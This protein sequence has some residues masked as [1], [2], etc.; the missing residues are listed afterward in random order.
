MCGILFIYDNNININ[1]AIKALDLLKKRGPDYTHYNIYNQLFIGQTTLEISGKYDI[2]NFTSDSN[3]Y[4]ISFNGEIY[5]SKLEND[6]KYLINLFDKIN[7]KEII[8]ELDG[9][10]CFGVYNKFKN[11]IIFARDMVGEKIMYYYHKDNIFIISS[12]ILPIIVYLK[13]YELNTDELYNYFFTRHL[14]TFNNTL[15]KDINCVLPGESFIFNINNNTIYNREIINIKSLINSKSEYNNKSDFELNEIFNNLIY[16]NAKEM[17]PNIDFACIISGGIDSSLSTAIISKIKKPTKC[18]ACYCEGKD[19]ITDKNMIQ[20]SNSINQKIDVLNISKEEWNNNLIDCQ[21]AFCS[22][23]V[24]HSAVNYSIMSKYISDNNIKVL[25]S[26]DGADELFGGYDCYLNKTNKINLYCPSN[27]SKLYSLKIKFTSLQ[28][29][30][31]KNNLQS[32][33][34]LSNKYYNDSKQSE[35]LCDSLTMLPEV[36]CKMTDTM[37]CLHGIE[38]RNIFY[39]KK[40]IEFILNCPLRIKIDFERNITKKLLKNQYLKYFNESTIKPKQGFAGYPNESI[41]MINNFNNI[42]KQLKINEYDKNDKTLM[43]KLINCEI[44]VTFTINKI[45]EYI[46]NES[47]NML[48]IL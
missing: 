22:P 6:T 23:I 38:I 47:V 32:I 24:S 15:I 48:R 37:G 2:N 1:R 3:N 18:V 35:L 28:S 21:L 40:I 34:K 33:W 42:I 44:F 14:M 30:K 26:A 41:I 13:N 16:E 36:G 9:M 10:Y 45:N 19:Y 11:E 12:E 43:W 7:Y 4:I 8:N 17:I 25:F 39:R 5:N 29:N 46:K 31:Y 20:H 27:Y